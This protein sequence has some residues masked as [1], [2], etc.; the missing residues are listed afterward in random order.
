MKGPNDIDEGMELEEVEEEVVL[1]KM[2]VEMVLQEGAQK[3]REVWW[4]YM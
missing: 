1:K 2:V 3:G 4:E